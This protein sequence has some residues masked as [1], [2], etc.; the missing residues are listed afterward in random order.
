MS[1]IDPAN[2]PAKSP[3]L[4]DDIIEIRISDVVDFLKKSRLQMLLGAVLGLVLGGIYAFS[5]ANEYTAQVTVLPELQTKSA[6]N[7]G[8]LGSLAGLAGIDIGSVGG[9]SDAIR[10]ELYPNVLQSAPYALALLKKTVYAQEFKRTQPLETYLTEKTKSKLGELFSFGGDDEEPAADPADT[11]RALR[12]TKQQENLALA[13]YSKVGG[14][15][16]KKTGVLGITSTMPD[17]NVAADVVRHSL[18]YLTDYITTYRTE[19]ARREVA[20]LN[21]QVAAAKQRYQVAELTLS[22]YRDQN[23]SVFL[24][25]AKIEEQR[26]QAEFLLAQDLYNTLSKQAEM[27][28][29]KVQENTPVFKVLEPARIPLKKSGP[30]R[31]LILFGAAVAGLFGGLVVAFLRRR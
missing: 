27:A 31:G 2:R 24:N 3:E 13:L 25:T 26:I 14:T 29:I 6:S 30:K 19:K 21:Q 10:P 20:F 18:A 28:K 7:L 5:K 8:N 17:P 16:D 11:S 23:R 15:Y 1:V 9:G 12:L 4:D 22:T